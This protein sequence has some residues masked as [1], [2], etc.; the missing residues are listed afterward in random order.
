MSGVE[1]APV[2]DALGR[3]G[4]GV[5]GAHDAPLDVEG[6][7]AVSDRVG[8]HGGDHEPDGVDVLAAHNRQH[9]PAQD[10]QGGD[11]HPGGDPC[12]CP[13]IVRTYADGDAVGVTDDP[14][15]LLR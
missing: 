6:V 5:V 13:S 3:G 9:P 2:V 15:L 11:D 4:V 12:G 1:V 14:L 8:A 7:E 10:A